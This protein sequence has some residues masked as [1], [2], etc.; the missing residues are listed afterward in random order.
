MGDVEE[1]HRPQGVLLRLRRQHPLRDVA[2]AARL[3]PGVPDRPPLHRDRHDEDGHRQVPVVREVRQDVQVAPPVRAL[4][5]GQL[6]VHGRQAADLRGLQREVG[7]GDHRRHL[8]EELDHVDDEHAPQ[9]G[10]GGEGH[11]EQAHEQQRL[12][13][14]EA[15]EDPRDLAGRQV[16]GGH[17]H[18]VEEEPQVDGAEPAHDARRL[19]RVADLVELEVGHDPRAPPQPRVEEDRRHPGQHERPPH[20]V[21]GDALAPHDVGHQVRGVAR[22]GGGDHGE[23]GQPPGHRAARGEEL[24]R[25]L[26]RPLPEEE[27]GDEADRQRR[28]DDHPVESLDVHGAGLYSRR[29]ARQGD[30]VP[31]IPRDSGWTGP[32][33]SAGGGSRRI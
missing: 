27:R 32:E 23:P 33:G 7:G 19:S 18:A 12:P 16:D 17:D 14:L 11:V 20:P 21:P 2:A 5:G 25:A 3:G 24:R 28:G 9:A 10:V 6:G 13:A 1:Q 15:E 30:I 26:A 29:P 4:H 22:E 31:V 8:D